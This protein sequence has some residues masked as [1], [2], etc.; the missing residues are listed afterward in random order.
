MTLSKLNIFV[1]GIAKSGGLSQKSKFVDNGLNEAWSFLRPSICK[2]T[3]CNL[4]NT[5]RCKLKNQV[6]ALFEQKLS[7][8]LVSRFVLKYNINLGEYFSPC[9]LLEYVTVGCI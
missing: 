8:Y 2:Y 1:C 9:L 5:L 6:N 4:Q 7:D 3:R